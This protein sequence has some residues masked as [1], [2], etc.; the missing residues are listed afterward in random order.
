MMRSSVDGISFEKV[1]KKRNA[2]F[3]EWLKLAEVSLFE[4]EISEA[5]KTS[6][7]TGRKRTTEVV[8]DDADF[9][10]LFLL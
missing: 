6:T 8:N 9:Y 10:P 1:K 3:E 2:P 5:Q 7:R 4:F